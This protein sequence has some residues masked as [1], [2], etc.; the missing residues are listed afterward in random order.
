MKRLHLTTAIFALTATAAFPEP[1]LN[2]EGEVGYVRLPSAAAPEYGE[3]SFTYYSSDAYE[4]QRLQFQAS[5]ALGLGINFSDGDMGA[6]NSL[7]A[8]IQIMQEGQYW[9]SFAIGFHDLYG[10][11][12]RSGEYAV[13]TKNFGPLETSLGLGWGA[14]SG[15]EVAFENGDRPAIDK[16]EFS[17]DHFFTGDASVFAGL[18]YRTPINGLTLSADYLPQDNGEDFAYG[19]QYRNSHRWGVGAY[20]TDEDNF[21]FAFTLAGNPRIPVTPQ[22]VGSPPLV[23]VPR[24]LAGVDRSANWYQPSPALTDGMGDALQELVEDQGARLDAVKI[25]A[26]TLALQVRPTETLV[27][28]KTIGRIT[29]ALAMA[30]PGSVENFE[31]TIVN[32]RGIPVSTA[33]INR[34]EYEAILEHPERNALAWEM[35]D[36]K[37]ATPLSG[38]SIYVAEYEKSRFDY[39]FNIST[40]LDLFSDNGIEFTPV[41]GA[42]YDITDALSINASG[43]IELYDVSTELDP[44]DADVR[45]RSD[46]ALYRQDLA[47]LDR[48]TADYFFKM[49]SSL[50]GRATAGLIETEY[51]GVDVEMIYAPSASPLAFGVELA[52]AYKRDPENVFGLEDYDTTTGFGTLYWDTG[53]EGLEMSYGYGRFLGEDW[54]SDVTLANKLRSGWTVEGGLVVPERFN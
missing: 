28:T 38:K 36:I 29:R 26:D 5:E 25:S 17:T 34:S 10:V 41:I 19:I 6:D 27:T 48:L 23:V 20:M 39:S 42:S 45:V 33:V 54:G 52:Q 24:N 3:T 53:F 8:K 44:T 35:V 30:A 43:S 13:A 40:N 14:L 9:P 51:A 46:R 21:G 50:Y 32:A 31:I 47:R 49:G 18:A 1:I 11:G 12:P 2:R 16:H 37:G 22:D 15:S 7:D 4:G